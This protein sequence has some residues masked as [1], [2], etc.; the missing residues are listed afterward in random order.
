M[1]GKF[2]ICHL[3]GQNAHILIQTHS[4]SSSIAHRSFSR[5]DRALVEA[6][7]VGYIA[8]DALV[9]VVFLERVSAGSLLRE[10]RRRLRSTYIGK[11]CETLA[12]STPAFAI[13]AVTQ[14]NV[15]VG[16]IVLDDDP[17]L[18]SIFIGADRRDGRGTHS[19]VI[20]SL[21]FLVPLPQTTLVL[22]M[23]QF[24]GVSLPAIMK[25]AGLSRKKS[26]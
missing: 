17:V 2:C 18:V 14:F 12:L 16:A 5:V 21:M 26:P 3:V 22:V 10:R 4:E 20:A 6:L 23:V 13:A 9:L 8:F 1:D 19:T 24:S 25:A 11:C 15:N 7:S